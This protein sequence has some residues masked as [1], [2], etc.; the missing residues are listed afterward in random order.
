MGD[1]HFLLTRLTSV[2]MK[3]I[4]I[5]VR[6]TS[7]SQI[8]VVIRIHIA[9]LFSSFATSSPPH[10]EQQLSNM[11]S[12]WRCLITKIAKWPRERKGPK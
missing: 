7:D 1:G 8:N 5:V 10:I 9:T 6:V 11:C 4:L 2:K 3:S 12:N